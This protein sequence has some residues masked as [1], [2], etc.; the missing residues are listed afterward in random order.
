[1]IL[2]APSRIFSR[3][4]KG[5]FAGGAGRLTTA[6]PAHTP[7][8]HSMKIPIYSSIAETAEGIQKKS[9]SPR[10]I[11]DAHLQGAA[12]LQHKLNAFVHLDAENARR[13]ALEAEEGVSGGITPG[14]PS[15][16]PVLKSWID[17]VG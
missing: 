4:Y 11:V 12:A 17:V 6:Q 15:G 8:L 14:P 5:F 3:Y 16:M 1:M 13:Q 10:K 9:G 2:L 7:S